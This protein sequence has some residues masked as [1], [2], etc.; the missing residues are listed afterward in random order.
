MYYYSVIASKFSEKTGEG[1]DAKKK[2]LQHENY[3]CSMY[4]KYVIIKRETFLR[5]T[6]W[7]R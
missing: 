6:N 1:S 7:I 2:I 5:N 4:R 3:V